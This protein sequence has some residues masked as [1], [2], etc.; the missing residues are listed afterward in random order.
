MPG[1]TPPSSA[2][3][4]GTPSTTTTG[5]DRPP[6]LVVTSGAERLEIEP[7]TYCWTSGTQAVCADGMPPDPLPEFE[8][9]VTELSIEYPIDW[10]MTTTFYPGDA[11]YCD[12]QIVIR[13]KPGGDS[14][15]PP[16]PSG[17]H[18][19]EVFAQ[20]EGGDG[21]WS[22]AFETTTYTDPPPPHAEVYWY[23]DIDESDPGV[24]IEVN[25]ANIATQPD[26]ATMSAV[27]TD[28]SGVTSEFSLDTTSD[29]SCWTGGLHGFADPGATAIPGGDAPYDIGIGIETDGE[30]WMV[31]PVRWPDEF[32]DGGNTSEW[33]T[34]DTGE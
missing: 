30:T 29:P 34:V 14:F 28:A 9:P 10:P 18:R 7:W 21:I 25:V 13:L 33:L 15:L 2:V 22:L 17:R 6:N 32:I 4:S 26:Q 27:V 24:S 12:G 11:E 16:V 19:V 23:Q 8:S 20:G 31:E 1:S 5:S 3:A